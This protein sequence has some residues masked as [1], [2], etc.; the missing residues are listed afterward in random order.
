MELAG[1]L[2]RANGNL[3]RYR[4]A[5]LFRAARPTALIYAYDAAD[6]L[7]G[8]LGRVPFRVACWSPYKFTGKERDS[9]SGLDMFGARYYGSGLGRFIST[10]WSASPEAVPYAELDDP[11]SLNLYAYSG[12]HPS[13][14][15]DPNG[16]CE[17]DKEKHGWVW[18][19]AHVL[20]FT[21]TRHER[22]TRM[23]YWLIGYKYVVYQHGRSVDLQKAS[24]DEIMQ[25]TDA[26]IEQAWQKD[27]ALIPAYPY[28]EKPNVTDSKLEKIVDDLYQPQD[29]VPGGTA[30]AVR[31][32]KLTGNLLSPAG[33][34]EDAQNIARQLNTFLKSNPGL[35]SNDQAVAKALIQDLENAVAGK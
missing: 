4:A 18:C 2:G 1:V 16:H 22:A 11:Q 25:I 15:I 5:V 10:D 24:D 3:N 14:R 7:Y 26:L 8:G 29:K 30:G 31:Y 19:A 17:V 27:E 23:R 9:E 32:E 21:Q 28:M 35:S 13:T 12:N 33:H 6:Y 34:V 20:G